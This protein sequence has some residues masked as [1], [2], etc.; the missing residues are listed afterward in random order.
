[1]NINAVP[2]AHLNKLKSSVSWCMA[3]WLRATETEISVAQWAKW[4]GKDFT[5]FLLFKVQISLDL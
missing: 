1:M 4:L 5:T 3:L 2:S